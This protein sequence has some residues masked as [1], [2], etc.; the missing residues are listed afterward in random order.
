LPRRPPEGV[1]GIELRPHRLEGERPRLH[2]VEPLRA[3]V[4]H[5]LGMGQRVENA[6]LHRGEADLGEHRA[7]HALDERAHHRL[8]VHDHLQRGTGLCPAPAGPTPPPPARP[9]SVTRSP[10]ITRASLLASATRL[11]ARSAASVAS[12]PAAPT[13]AFTTLP[14]SGCVAASTRQAFPVPP[15]H[16]PRPTTVRESFRMPPPL[17]IPTSAGCHSATWPSRSSAFQCAI[18]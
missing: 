6:Q 9:A 15:S 13:I 10:A 1:G 16:A 14:T 8:G 18:S 17:T 4:G 11:P 3:A 7:I 12:R 5:P 2:G